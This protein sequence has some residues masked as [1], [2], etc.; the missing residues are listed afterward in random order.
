[1]ISN[2]PSILLNIVVN[3]FISNNEY[4]FQILTAHPTADVVV[5]KLLLSSLAS[6]HECAKSVLETESRL[7]ILIN[8]AGSEAF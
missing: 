4:V 2:Y 8:N 7:D 6:V 1:M 3:S 5:K